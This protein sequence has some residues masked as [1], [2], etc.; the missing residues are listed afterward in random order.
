M[1]KLTVEIDQAVAARFPDITVSGF[2]VHGLRTAADKLN[3]T[4][5]LQEAVAS[6]SEH[7]VTSATLGEEPRIA[8]WRN[9]FRLQGLKP[10]RYRTSPDALARRVLRGDSI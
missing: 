3:G 9:A 1:H 5:L 2:I 10:S 8:A 7:G 4:Q 6:L